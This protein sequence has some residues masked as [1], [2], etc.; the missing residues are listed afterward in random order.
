MP[1][2]RRKLKSLLL[3]KNLKYPKRSIKW[4]QMVLLCYWIFQD[5]YLTTKKSLRIHRVFLLIW[6]YLLR[7]K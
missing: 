6:W 3:Q 1:K 5:P 2:N 4:M 7:R